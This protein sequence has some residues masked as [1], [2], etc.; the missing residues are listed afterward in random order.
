MLFL[1]GCRY[2]DQCKKKDEEWEE[3]GCV[4]KQCLIRGPRGYERMVTVSQLGRVLIARYHG[5]C[6]CPENSRIF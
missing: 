4:R 2:K 6:K 1:T 3:V 5:L